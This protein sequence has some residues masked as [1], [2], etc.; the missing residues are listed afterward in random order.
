MVTTVGE[1]EATVQSVGVRDLK[2]HLSAYLRAASAGETIV[3]TRHG[4]DF[5]V[6]RS[7]DGEAEGLR[8]LLA[9]GRA[10]WS[11]RRPSQPRDGR[12]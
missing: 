2:A 7:A 5:A 1:S 10:T 4:V 8:R 6:L 12:S 9:S 11:G 3:V